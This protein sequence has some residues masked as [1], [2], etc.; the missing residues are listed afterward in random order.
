MAIL[1]FWLAV[2]E[3]AWQLRCTASLPNALTYKQAPL[4]WPGASFGNR[5]LYPSARYTAPKSADTAAAVSKGKKEASLGMNQSKETMRC[6]YRGKSKRLHVCGAS[7][8]RVL[9]KGV[10]TTDT[11]PAYQCKRSIANRTSTRVELRRLWLDHH[12]SSSESSSMS[13]L[14]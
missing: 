3:E 12:A 10:I 8:W 2:F 5:I 14:R 9:K 4:H 6:P 7:V 11:N 1:G 13:W